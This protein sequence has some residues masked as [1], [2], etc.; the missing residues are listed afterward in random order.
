MRLGL[1]IL[2]PLAVLCANSG[3]CAKYVCS[4]EFSTDTACAKQSFDN[5][6]VIKL[7]K[8]SDESKVCDIKEVEDEEGLCSASYST[9]K[10]F[11][12]EYCRA[13]SECYSLKCHNNTC[14][15]HSLGG[16]CQEDVECDSGLYC[17]Q[18][19][20]V[21]ALGAGKTCSEE[22]K[23]KANLVCDAGTCVLI[24]SK[25]DGE[26]SSMQGACA[27]FFASNGK[28]KHGPTLI[29]Q[30]G[31]TKCPASGQCEYN[32]KDEKGFSL[33]CTCG[34]TENGD[35][36]CEPGRGDVDISAVR[37]IFTNFSILHTSLEIL[38]WAK[39][40]M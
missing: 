13:D 15:G 2:I 22:I 35:S 25:K 27:S 10:F 36:F 29:D 5:G 19:Q 18:G 11:P 16:S 30:G 28:C 37:T 38:N 3:E 40:A 23:C 26:D 21:S 8:C 7:R 6:A 39:S 20:C 9:P 24:G 4:K 17:A 14:V 34:M 33:P 12:G 31:R 1:L 32:V